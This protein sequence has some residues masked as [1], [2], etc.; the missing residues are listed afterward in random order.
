LVSDVHAAGAATGGRAAARAL[1]AQ[2]VDVV[3]GIPG[4]HNL[5]LYAGLAEAGIRHLSPRHEQ[6]AAFA[7]DGY[8]RVSGRPGVCVTTSGPAVLNAATALAQAYSD[9]VPVLLVSAGMPVRHPGLGNGELHET[10]DLAAAMSGV[11]AY[12]HRV[13]SVEE[14]PVAI[15][16]AFGRMTSGRPRPVHVE[17]PF[18]VLAESAAVSIVPHVRPAAVAPDADAVRAAA[19]LLRDAE[20]PAILAGGGAC[21]AARELQ[22][23]AERLGAP[24]VCS[25]N[26]KGCLPED[27]PLSAGAGYARPAVRALAEDSDVVLVAGSELAPSDAW[28]AP[29]PLDGKVVRVDVDPAQAVTNA[30]PAEV[31]IG[32]AAL[33][34]DALYQALHGDEAG[35]GGPAPGRLDRAARWAG[36]AA[37]DARHDAAPWAAL[38]DVIAGAAGRDGVL[39]ADSVMAAYFGAVGAVPSYRPR[40]FLYPTGFGTLGYAVPAAMGGKVARPDA[41][42]VVL[43]GDGGVMFSVAELAAAAHAGLDMAVVIVDNDGYG[44]IRNEMRERGDDLVGTELPSPDFPALARALGCRGVRADTREG[45]AAALDGAFGAG[46]PTVIHV[47]EHAAATLGG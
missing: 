20:R 43:A 31:V 29:L 28:Y 39:V 32:D 33:A 6:G 1:A 16:Q 36:A 41:R 26:G 15:A 47:P 18:D 17:I 9:S 12:S 2:G 5:E 38:L 24:V 21:G 19:A 4:T 35:D 40:S 11:V 34:L 22:R 10:K 45:V 42:V 46:R 13:T 37:A 7:A 44:E 14:V 8:S 25:I 27:H 3:W 30:V 23:L